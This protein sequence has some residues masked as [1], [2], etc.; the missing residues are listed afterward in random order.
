MVGLRMTKVKAARG[1]PFKAGRPPSAERTHGRQITICGRATLGDLHPRQPRHRVGLAGRNSR[2]PY[3]DTRGVAI[4]YVRHAMLRTARGNA[5]PS[6]TTEWGCD[7]AP[8]VRGVARVDDQ[9]SWGFTSVWR[10][11]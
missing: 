8:G 11:T 9:T 5:R 4:I 2:R 3:S 1:L 10:W 7:N 6:I